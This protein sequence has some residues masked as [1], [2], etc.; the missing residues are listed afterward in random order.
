MAIKHSPGC[1]CC[2]EEGGVCCNQFV[3]YHA[4]VGTP[5]DTSYIQSGSISG[6]NPEVI[7][8]PLVL[9]IPT[10]CPDWIID[11]ELY[12]TGEDAFVKVDRALQFRT[13][14][15][16]N[17]TTPA[18][19][20]DEN[21]SEQ[22]CYTFFE[23]DLTYQWVHSR[24]SVDYKLPWRCD[25][26]DYGFI[27][28]APSGAT[29]NGQPLTQY[30]LLYFYS[31]FDSYY[32]CQREGVVSPALLGVND[33]AVAW[34]RGGVV[35]AGPRT[36]LVTIDP[37]TDYIVLNKIGVKY[38]T[39]GN[40]NDL[41]QDC[42]A[43]RQQVYPSKTSFFTG[44]PL[45]AMS[46]NASDQREHVNFWD[47]VIEE[48]GH[49][50]A[51][52]AFVGPPFRGMGMPFGPTVS[53]WPNSATDPVASLGSF[54]GDL[55]KFNDDSYVHSDVLPDL[56]KYYDGT[57]YFS[58]L[59]IPLLSSDNSGGNP[60]GATR[61]GAFP[62]YY[63]APLSSMVPEQHSAFRGGWIESVTIVDNNTSTT[64][65]L[66]NSTVSHPALYDSGTAGSPSCVANTVYGSVVN[67]CGTQGNV[68][69]YNLNYPNYPPNPSYPGGGFSVGQT[70]V[71]DVLRMQD[72]S[73]SDWF[74]RLKLP[75]SY[76][77]PLF[78][79]F[80]ARR[81]SDCL[82][83]M[84]HDTQFTTLVHACG[85]NGLITTNLHDSCM[86]ADITIVWR[87]E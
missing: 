87:F 54:A 55:S 58:W 41:S 69:S 23:Q 31:I 48:K 85:P 63:V 59:Q 40:V 38:G 66:S 81:S 79:T 76:I 13:T 16:T 68:E 70:N 34:S 14:P 84:S 4:S 7:T 42:S 82:T 39:K 21:S 71:S 12:R 65:N 56:W 18:Y 33:D 53:L 20:I 75:S 26:P 22:T 57:N 47:S 43:I 50:S 37:G 51:D 62:L 86:N 2:E 67:S 61:L 74:V 29:Y 5:F 46:I 83:Y 52:S 78:L 3:I 32:G 1:R 24:L 45:Y 25:D 11:I 80:S 10:C 36:T 9:S 35:P 77:Q 17:A 28:D 19:R 64:F 60:P 72:E 73:E 44:D 15:Y 30:A 27:Y 8:S 49:I 6:S